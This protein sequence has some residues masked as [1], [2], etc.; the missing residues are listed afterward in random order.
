MK[1]TLSLGVVDDCNAEG[2]GQRETKG[3][4][5]DELTLKRDTILRRASGIEVLHRSERESTEAD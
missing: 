3:K 2:G 4:A 1:E 5:D